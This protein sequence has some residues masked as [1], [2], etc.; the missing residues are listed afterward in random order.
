MWAAP[1]LR[2]DPSFETLEEDEDT[3]RSELTE[4]MRSIQERTF[5]DGGQALRAVHAKN[6]GVLLGTLHV[7]AGLPRELA[8]GLFA[9]AGSFDVVMRFST[10]PGDLLDDAVS[11]PRGLAVK[12]IGVQG[13]R[14]PGSEGDVTQDFLFVN[15]PAFLK[16]DGKS[17]VGS[18]KLLGATTDKAPK[19]KKVVSA[20][21]RGVERTI[22]AAGGHSATVIG[23]GGQPL[24]HPLIDTYFS[25][26][27]LLYGEYMAKLSLVPASAT[28]AAIDRAP[29]DAKDDPDVL[30]HA[31]GVFFATQSAGWELRVQLCTDLDAMP[32]ENSK[33][34]WPEDRS[35]YV[36]V[37]QLVV[38][39]QTTDD[40]ARAMALDEGLSF[41]PWHGLAAH[42]PLGS[43]NR[44]RRSVYEHAR[45][46]RAER[47]GCPLAEPRSVAELRSY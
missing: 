28:L 12:V 39:A 38:P 16:K 41:S 44:L 31:I 7:A 40:V 46:F 25:Q 26:T 30:R 9:L 17:F 45:Q 23:L 24:T 33:T 35:S 14:L 43:I 22:E 29:L 21:M 8:Q 10:N 4:A 2:F 34:V 37:A 36:T 13:E 11:V 32:I 20:V 27:P 15:G 3:T 19:T 47:S 5:A 42:R 18:V 6:H 1:P